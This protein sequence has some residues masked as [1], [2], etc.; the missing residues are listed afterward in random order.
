MDAIFPFFSQ[1]FLQMGKAKEGWMNPYLLN[2][3]DSFS[4][5]T[6]TTKLKQATCPHLVSKFQGLRL[7]VVLP[8]PNPEETNTSRT[9]TFAVTQPRRACS[10]ILG[11]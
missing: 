11:I 2:S 3:K 6:E 1:T 7:H 4:I 8:G 10:G 9:V 5:Q